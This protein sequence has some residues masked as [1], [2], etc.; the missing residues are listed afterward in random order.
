MCSKC[1]SMNVTEVPPYFIYH[2][3]GALSSSPTPASLSLWK[4]KWSQLCLTF[5]DPMG[6]SLPGSSIHGLFRARVL[7]WVAISFSRRSSR[8]RDGTRVSCIVGR[9]FTVWA[10][11]EV[12]LLPWCSPSQLP[13]T[14]VQIGSLETHLETFGDRHEKEELPPPHHPSFF[15]SAWASSQV[16]S[17]VSPLTSVTF[18]I[19]LRK[20][21]WWWILCPRVCVCLC[22]NFP[23][24]RKG[25]KWKKK[26]GWKRL[27]V[28]ASL[29]FSL[30]PSTNF[31]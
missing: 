11:R 6:C 21:Y 25:I 20:I 29:L 14:P 9:R 12:P 24:E 2:P 13:L 8:P 7:E 27:P 30:V 5:C 26:T 3:D 23:L 17:I 4:W 16:A 19:M 10:T 1:L 18:V 15:A 22:F 28:S 31:L